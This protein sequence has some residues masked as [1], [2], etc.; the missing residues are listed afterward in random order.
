MADLTK[1]MEVFNGIH[2]TEQACV[3]GCVGVYRHK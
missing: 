1:I 2:N 3:W